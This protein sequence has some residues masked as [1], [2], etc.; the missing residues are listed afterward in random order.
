M[1]YWSFRHYITCRSATS[2]TASKVAVCRCRAMS[3]DM[4]ATSG[5]V[6]RRRTFGRIHSATSGPSTGIASRV[7]RGPS[8]QRRRRAQPQGRRS[9]T[10]CGV[11]TTGRPQLRYSENFAGEHVSMFGDDRNNRNP[12]SDAFMRDG[13]SS[14]GAF[15]TVKEFVGSRRPRYSLVFSIA[16]VKTSRCALAASRWI[17]ANKLR[18][19]SCSYHSKKRPT[20]VLSV[21][22]HI[23]ANLVATVGIPA[24]SIR[25]CRTRHHGQL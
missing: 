20:C 4:P 1:P 14:C 13:I 9:R 12:T 21:E 22:F 2:R 16:E 5:H 11:I 8:R 25:I 24:K 6:Q 23:R 19:S 7:S 15:I 17:L 18:S 3:S 10:T